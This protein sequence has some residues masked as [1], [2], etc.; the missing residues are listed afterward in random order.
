MPL[1]G[2]GGWGQFDSSRRFYS[3]EASPK[4]SSLEWF[5]MLSKNKNKNCWYVYVTFSLFLNLLYI[6]GSCTFQLLQH[7]QFF[8]Y[9]LHSPPS[10]A[11][12]V[13]ETTL[14]LLFLSMHQ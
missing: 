6:C 13:C 12:V 1:I 4:G 3:L 9:F 10:L 5:P 7:I 8:S 14:S 11:L 2:S